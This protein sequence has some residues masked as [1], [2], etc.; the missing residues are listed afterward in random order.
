MPGVGEIVGGSMRTWKY[1][2]LMDGFK[3]NNIDPTPYYWYTD[4]VRWMSSSSK[5]IICMN[6]LF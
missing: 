2:E 5:T 3:R 1:E 4:Q 6:M